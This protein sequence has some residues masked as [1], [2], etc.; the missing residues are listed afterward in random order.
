LPA[1]QSAVAEIPDK[2][3]F[4]IGEV[5]RLAELKPYVLRYWETEFG[6]L[7]P[8]K[9]RSGQRLYKRSDV[10]LVLRIKTLLKER[11]FT[12]AGARAELRKGRVV[13]ATGEDSDTVRLA[14]ASEPKALIPSGE[15]SV[16]ADADLIERVRVQDELL[17]HLRSELDRLRDLVRSQM[18][19]V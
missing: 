2:I 16:A 15:G 18:P 4:K 7:K 11:K 3:F 12:I 5:A 6:V 9:S 8:K 10:E 1:G 14:P 19:P 17:R 13:P